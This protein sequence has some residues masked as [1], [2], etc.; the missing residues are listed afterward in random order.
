M[1]SGKN[2][3]DESTHFRK[4]PRH[5]PYPY[6]PHVIIHPDKRSEKRITGTVRNESKNGFSALFG[7]GFPYEEGDILDVRV[8]FQRAWAKIIWVKKLTDELYVAGFRLHPKGY[9]D[10]LE[11]VADQDKHL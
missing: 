4:E 3:T 7:D 10:D 6:L 1:A 11:K 9:L 8:G 2:E 5:S